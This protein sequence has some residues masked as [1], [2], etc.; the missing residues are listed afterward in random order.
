[1][2]TIKEAIT[3]AQEA[4]DHACLQH[5]LSLLQRIVNEHDKKRLLE[6]SVSKCGELNLPYLQSL[7]LLSLA[8]HLSTSSSTDPGHVLDLIAKSELINCHQSMSDLQV[9]K[10][11]ISNLTSRHHI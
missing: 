3:M 11:I 6:R 8:T 7:G 10:N 1:M 4:S 2:S 9:I 5:V